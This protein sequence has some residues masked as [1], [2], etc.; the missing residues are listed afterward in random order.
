MRLE[1]EKYEEGEGGWLV[2]RAERRRREMM[3]REKTLKFGVKKDIFRKKKKRFFKFAC[4]FLWRTV[5]LVICMYAFIIS[6][7]HKMRLVQET[8]NHC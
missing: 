5:P 3:R 4:V 7:G 2:Q 6:H 8:F 1:R